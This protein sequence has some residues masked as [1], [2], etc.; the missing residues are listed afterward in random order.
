MATTRGETHLRLRW[1]EQIARVLLVGMLLVLAYNNFRSLYEFPRPDADRWHGDETWLMRE[2]QTQVDEGIFQYPEA[3]GSTLEHGNGF[4]LGSMWLNAIAYGVPAVLGNSKWE[5]ISTGRTVTWVVSIILL[6]CVYRMG[7][8]FG[9]GVNGALIVL[10]VLSGSRAWLYGTH[11]ARYDIWVALGVVCVLW[12]LSAIAERKEKEIGKSEVLLL[13]LLP[14]FMM[15]WNVHVLRI[16]GP[17]WF[18]YCLV[19]CWSNKKRLVEIGVFALGSAMLVLGLYYIT[20]GSFAPMSAS[21]TTSQMRQVLERIPV[22]HPFAFRTQLAN[23]QLRHDLMHDE[24]PL[25]LMVFT[26]MLVIF[27]LSFFSKRRS[28]IAN[29][30]QG[31]NWLS[32]VCILSWGLTT[33]SLPYYLPQI[34]PVMILA[35]VVVLKQ[36][37]SAFTWRVPAS[38]AS[39][40]VLI[41][42][43]V[44][45]YAGVE[46]SMLAAKSGAVVSNSLKRAED[47]IRSAIARSGSVRPV[48]MAEPPLVNL[49]LSLHNEW[50]FIAPYYLTYPLDTSIA[51]G[52]SPLPQLHA[53]HVEFVI[54]EGNRLMLPARY[55]LGDHGFAADSIG[56]LYCQ[57]IGPFSD[58]DRDYFSVTPQPDDTISVFRIK[59]P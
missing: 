42:A 28:E 36:R 22:L 1:Y 48:V 18:A 6:L 5:I 23:I 12:I 59:N 54:C 9:L 37:A 34:L 40:F 4:I 2:F 27:L 53:M 14:V 16:A 31:F 7:R 21:A 41:V 46:E 44:V 26:V 51:H 11:S 15:V 10:L 52:G 38:L 49:G 45:C 20:S 25:V 47:E 13:G 3:L 43:G 19:V 30:S 33:R 29:H 8:R 24:A 50:R 35:I 55:P 39:A 56:Q 58:H 17:A 32:L 57:C